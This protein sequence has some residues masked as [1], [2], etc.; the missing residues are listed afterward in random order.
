M[1]VYARYMHDRFHTC[2]CA[3]E[4]AMTKSLFSSL[5]CLSLEANWGF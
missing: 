4:N 3:D 5:H 1:K 2:K